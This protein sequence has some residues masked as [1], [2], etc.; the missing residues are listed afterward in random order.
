M[1]VGLPFIFYSEYSLRSLLVCTLYMIPN[2]L[3]D[4]SH[5]YLS[6]FLD[7]FRA[8]YAFGLS[9]LITLQVQPWALRP[10]DLQLYL[11]FNEGVGESYSLAFFPFISVQL[12][13]GQSAT[14]VP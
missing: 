6:L 9:I 3:L 7:C 1:N 5:L 12:G 8:E 13:D 2:S 14:R 10:H 4:L 11:D